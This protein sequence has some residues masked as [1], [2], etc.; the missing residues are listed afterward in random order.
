MAAQPTFA[1]LPPELHHMIIL[2]LTPSAAI[3][4]GGTNR[5]FRSLN[6][7]SRL[8]PLDVKRYF[9]IINLR[10]V[11]H[12]SFLCTSCCCVK[13]PDEFSTK[14]LIGEWSKRGL[15]SWSRQCLEC[16]FDTIEP[17]DEVF[18]GLREKPRSGRGR[19]KQWRERLAQKKM[20]MCIDCMELKDGWCDEC[21]WCWGCFQSRRLVIEGES[22]EEYVKRMREELPCSKRRHP[23]CGRVPKT[24][25][26]RG[27]VQVGNG[28]VC[29]QRPLTL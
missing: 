25:G 9:R 12:S 16:M 4:L 28:S 20:V 19:N 21:R 5:Y 24:S 11:D 23:W 3:A 17:G 27:P 26:R 6:C 7:L 18:L 15:K 29:V 22:M 13:P 1:S 10:M 2:E 8:D 14:R